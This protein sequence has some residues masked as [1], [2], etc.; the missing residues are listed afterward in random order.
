MIGA[1]VDQ[2]KITKALE[3]KIVYEVFLAQ[4]IQT[5][6]LFELQAISPNLTMSTGFSNAV[7]NEIS[8]LI[9]LEHPAILCP[10]NIL[11]VDNRLYVVYP[12]EN[13]RSL[14]QMFTASSGQ[15]PIDGLMRIFKD[16]LRALGF[17]HQEGFHHRSLN[18]DAIQVNDEGDAKLR[19]FGNVLFES[20]EKYVGK[21]EMVAFARYYAPERFSNP[22]TE[23]IRANIYSLGAILYQMTTGQLPIDG[24]SLFRLEM[25]HADPEH[26]PSPAISIRADLPPGFSEMLAKALD[27]KAENR[28]QNPIEFYKEIEKIESKKRSALFNED[29][30]KGFG[31]VENDSFSITG[32]DITEHS[33]SFKIEDPFGE[34]DFN[35][36]LESHRAEPKR[37][38]RF[39]LDLTVKDS[40]F[41]PKALSNF[42]FNKK[43][44]GQ[45]SSEDR[46]KSKGGSGFLDNSFES[47]EDSDPFGL[48]SSDDS[49]P[50]GEPKSNT[51]DFGENANDPF[52]S[53]GDMDSKGPAL[54]DFSFDLPREVPTPDF[55]EPSK[56][57]SPF[58]FN[59]E[60]VDATTD[61]QR[62][63]ERLENRESEG[64]MIIER[65]DTYT[66]VQQEFTSDDGAFNFTPVSGDMGHFDDRL[67]PGLGADPQMPG[68]MEELPPAM[69]SVRR[70]DQKLQ[71]SLAEAGKKTLRAQSLKR[72]NPM[73]PVLGAVALILVLAFGWF[74]YKGYLQNQEF[75][76]VTSKIKNL[77]DK[78]H[79]KQ[80][81]TFVS[82]ALQK[83]FSSDQKKQIEVFRAHIEKTLIEINN[84]IE[85]HFEKARIFETQGK[86][87]VD[88]ENDAFAEFKRISQLDPDN[89]KA[90]QDMT[91]IRD[92]EMTQI[93]QMIDGGQKMDAL[94]K[95]R[96]LN[97]NYK[98]ESIDEQY[99]VLLNILKQTRGKDLEDQLVN[100]FENKKYNELLPIYD[101]LI[102]IDPES[103]FVKEKS[104]SISKD[105]LAIG[106]Q[107]QEQ[108]KY[109][110]AEEFY[111]IAQSLT[112][113]DQKIVAKIESVK[114][115]AEML[116]VEKAENRLEDAQNAENLKEQLA[117]AESLSEIDPGNIKANN[118]LIELKEAVRLK[119]VEADRMR[120]LGRFKEAAE[121]YKLIYDINGKDDVKNLWQEYRSWA[122]PKGMIYIPAGRFSIGSN[123]SSLTRPAHFVSLSPFYVDKC[124]I[125]NSKFKEF[126]DATPQWGPGRIPAD[127]HDGNYL[128]HWENGSP[129]PGT[130]NQPVV[131][132][133]YYAAKAYA[134][135]VGKRLLTEAEWEAAAAGGTKDQKY[136]WGNSSSA[137]NA[138]YN[139]YAQRRPA[140]VASF[141]ANEYEIFEILGNVSEWVE[142][143]YDPEFYKKSIDATDPV[144]S[145]GSEHIHRGGSF[146]HMGREITITNRF[147]E[148]P[149]TCAPYIGFR[150]GRDAR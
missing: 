97:Q 143:S 25:A 144:C 126:V 54:N 9:A 2:F 149:K 75:Q 103:K 40:N 139:K 117:A 7:K 21:E 123:S 130:E 145:T 64:S 93:S 48:L 150:C 15:F 134:S 61:P 31:N 23:D 132:V 22:G 24:E 125:T 74:M 1:T 49:F 65:N 62:E 4:H 105:L 17:A 10:A 85:T 89:V 67:D 52:G 94:Q 128:K 133:S 91:R 102:R 131:Y 66:P 70:M 136:W 110:K 118:A 16:I 43:P 140:P 8:H 111:L 137:T 41:D 28:F 146:K 108:K 129:V 3:N 12:Y 95:L 80:A 98:D 148:D 42:G 82:E 73:V 112:P 35:I 56:D 135:Y 120:S 58:D 26:R 51:F 38:D 5:G 147:V 57:E 119:R 122:P 45:K 14:R 138:V 96:V 63:M 90:V 44:S 55:G 124:E 113:K 69:P 78:S 86:R 53:L 109:E 92:L 114:S 88:G 60:G 115:N 30:T 32:D 104:N 72:K 46:L 141:P 101:E 37:D 68:L 76:E 127:M 36:G 77:L 79:F 121:Q 29:F 11:E 27:K 34:A 19:N 106:E 33:S 83:D 50:T 47:E 18:L 142:D 81:R 6:A 13:A 39:D 116:R 71:D 107:F 84:E 100:V 20:L 99:R 59:L 87:L